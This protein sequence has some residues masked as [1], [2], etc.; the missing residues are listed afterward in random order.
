MLGIR[1][2]TSRFLLTQQ[3]IK[4]DIKIDSPEQ[5]ADIARA[6][7]EAGNHSAVLVCNPLPEDQALDTEKIN[8]VIEEA[9]NEAETQGISGSALTPFLLDKV[10]KISKGESLQTNLALLR[11]N[12]M[13]AARIAASMAKPY[14]ILIDSMGL[15][16]LA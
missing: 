16:G 8:Q 12:A 4:I 6:H 14:I 5:A 10:G 9:I 13:L 2:K 7:W 1:P 15:E 3:R 11:N